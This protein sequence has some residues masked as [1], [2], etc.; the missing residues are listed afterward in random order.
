MDH[1]FVSPG[2]RLCITIMI[3]SSIVTLLAVALQLWFVAAAVVELDVAVT[4]VTSPDVESDWTTVYYSDKKP[5][6]IGNDGGPDK[7][8][9]HAYGL[10]S[11]S[12][13]E[14]AARVTGRTKLV[15]TVYGVGERDLIVTIAQP[16]SVMRVFEAPKLEHVSEA[17]REVLG[18]WSALCSWKS[19]TENNYVY[20][21]GKNQAVQL[22]VRETKKK[23]ES[24]EILEVRNCLC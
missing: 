9:F 20:L 19:P 23:E 15:T 17:D 13:K 2:R 24:V 18:D 3:L 11:E 10:G 12:L 5:L 8:G 16:D 7:G 1:A 21:F 14:V 6:L 22:L 4:A